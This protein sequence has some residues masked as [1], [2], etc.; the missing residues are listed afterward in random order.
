MATKRIFVV[1]GGNKG[2]GFEICRALGGGG[3]ESEDG[4]EDVCVFGSRD[5]TRGREAEERLKKEGAKNVKCFQL[6]ICDPKSVESFAKK[7]AAIGKVDVLINNAAIAFKSKDPTPHT[8]QA[9]PTFATN[10]FG[11]IDFTER[12]LPLMREGGQGKIVNVASQAGSSAL[13]AMSKER[14]A[15]L[16]DTSTSTEKLRALAKN[17]VL[18]TEAGDQKSK[19]WA[20]SNYGQSKAFVIA[21][22]RALQ[23]EYA[24]SGGKTGPS[25]ASCCPGWCATDMSSHMGPR[26]A[27]KGAETPV[28]LARSPGALDGGFYYDKRRIAYRG[29]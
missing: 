14:V 3:A 9:R 6:D 29:E 16:M 10:V 13:K 24:A 12:M 7:V 11:T 27:S 8:K 18:D 22:T 21:W 26:S 17:F 28:W 20:G 19:G 1:T 4:K 15:E 25:V 5:E 23:R 2:I